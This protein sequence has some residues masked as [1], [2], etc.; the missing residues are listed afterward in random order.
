MS[1]IKQ[2]EI[3]ILHI[4]ECLSAAGIESFIMNNYRKLDRS[5]VQFDFLIL[6]NQEE[7][8]DLEIQSL[9]GK[10]YTICK[11]NKNTLIRILKESIELYHFLCEHSY[12]IIH[13]HYTT[14]LRAP[15]LFAAKKAGVPVRIYHSHSAEVS[16]KS[17]LKT[18]I[19][20]IM[21]IKIEKWATHY[22][23]CSNAAAKW[24][25]PKK[26]CDSHQV[27]VI[28]NGIDIQKYSYYEL[29]RKEIRDEL[30][31]GRSF[32]LVHTGRFLEQKN[33]S[34]IID[35]FVELKKKCPE[36]ILL[37]LGEGE[38]QKAVKNKVVQ[39]NLI[40]SVL[41]LN[42]RSDVYKILSASDCYIMPSLYEGLP[43]AAV[44]AQCSSLPCVLSQNITKEIKLTDKVSFLSLDDPI[45]IWV[46]EI[47][48]Y[49]GCIRND[50]SQLILQHGYD[51][52]Q[53]AQL[54]QDFYCNVGKK[55]E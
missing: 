50:E 24:I 19:Y 47:L 10:K 35:I 8:Y 9:G 42:V 41:F 16:G 36:A 54:L 12:N 30:N 38:L 25:F 46:Q 4:T 21:K 22:F 34:F 48:K 39:K 15:Y 11:S 40:E 23:A 5:K 27:N 13:I 53:V 32:V 45:E 37:L 44:E 26:L 2:K 55:Y 52:N 29:Y 3:R 51:A 6:R 1:S 49:K 20:D 14:P 43:V 18:V 33:Q 17:K 31:L 28:Y 7:F